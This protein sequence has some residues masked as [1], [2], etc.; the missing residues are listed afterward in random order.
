MAESK[1]CQSC[2]APYQSKF[3]NCVYCG[4]PIRSERVLT[5]VDE[6]RIQWLLEIL[7]TRLWRDSF[8][9][10]FSIFRKYIFFLFGLGFLSFLFS[11][12]LT[13]N[14]FTSIG[15][16]LI[17]LLNPVFSLYNEFENYVNSLSL[18]HYFNK[19]TKI[20]LNQFMEGYNHSLGDIEYVMYKNKGFPRIKQC[21]IEKR[22]AA[23]TS[24]GLS[25]V[26]DHLSEL[27]DMSCYHQSKKKTS[28]F[29]LFS[30]LGLFLFYSTILILSSQFF[31]QWLSYTNYISLTIC[32]G[33]S[34][35][36]YFEQKDVLNFIFHFLGYNP[37]DKLMREKWD[38]VKSYFTLTKCNEADFRKLLDQNSKYV[39]LN[40]YLEEEKFFSGKND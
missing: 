19:K 26:V 32:L 10:K 37:D 16:T 27:F 20:I 25:V 18:V 39:R 30:G 23:D 6:S 11:F 21:M 40:I 28:Y 3:E 29:F 33:I 8:E 17:I 15:I 24:T 22:K 35:W 14:I 4:E 38:L 2:G 9:Y 34:V 31:K 7:D 13:E 36:F 12:F 1:D 5:S